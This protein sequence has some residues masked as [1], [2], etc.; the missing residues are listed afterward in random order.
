MRWAIAARVDASSI[1]P[2]RSATS[3]NTVAV[4]LPVTSSIES[5]SF[6]NATTP[7]VEIP[8]TVS[9]IVL[10]RNRSPFVIVSELAPAILAACCKPVSPSVVVPRASASFDVRSMAL[11]A[12]AVSAPIPAIPATPAIAPPNA[13]IFA[14]LAVSPPANDFALIPARLSPLVN[15][16]LLSPRMADIFE[17]VTAIRPR[18]L[19]RFRLRLR[20]R[21]RLRRAEVGRESRSTVA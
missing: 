7:S 11:N 20:L 18:S 5:P 14:T 12:D 8:V 6:S 16:L 3:A 21:L 19:R 1:F 17:I 10:L 15:P 4:S 9:P 13:P 2:I